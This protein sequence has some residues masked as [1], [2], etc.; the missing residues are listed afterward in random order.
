M[1]SRLAT[2][3]LA[4]ENT[5]TACVQLFAKITV[6]VILELLVVNTLTGAV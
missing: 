3:W 5:V 1:N 2:E 6:N 4:Q